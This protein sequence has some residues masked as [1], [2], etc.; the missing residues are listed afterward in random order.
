ADA[1]GSGHRRGT[2]TDDVPVAEQVPALL[3]SRSFVIAD[4]GTS[5][6][7]LRMLAAAGV[8]FAFGSAGGSGGV[9]DWIRHA[10]FG[11]DSGLSARAAFNATTR[12]G[13][14]LAGVPD[15]G[16]LTIG[17]DATFNVWACEQFEVQV[18]D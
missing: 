4:F 1:P 3:A 9:W 17:S 8:P 15:S 18:P 16:Q 11:S 2:V 7:T 14:R 10:V 5:P 13:W 6:S 12:S